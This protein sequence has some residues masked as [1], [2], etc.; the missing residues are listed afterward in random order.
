MD[1]DKDGQLTTEEMAT[2]IAKDT[3]DAAKATAAEGAMAALDADK[4]GVIDTGELAAVVGSTE[5]AE[6][7]V[8]KADTDKDGQ[9]SMEEATAEATASCPK[10]E[11]AANAAIVA[12]AAKA[13]E[14]AGAV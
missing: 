14:E 6:A 4:D 5:V 3:K 7:I 10:V 2:S 8:Q 11:V 1:S 9:L 12:D 13:N